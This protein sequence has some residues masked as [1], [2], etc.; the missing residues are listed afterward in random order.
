M[1]EGGVARWKWRVACRSVPFPARVPR[2]R[3]EDDERW[4]GRDGSGG[5]QTLPCPF[6]H[7]ILGTG[8]RM[9]RAGLAALEVG[10]AT[11]FC[12]AVGSGSARHAPA[13]LRG[14]GSSPGRP[15]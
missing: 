2:D 13:W 5:C 1:T 8:P 12:A 9:T 11:P 3:P 14:G 4:V 15:W 6:L 7:G 10:G